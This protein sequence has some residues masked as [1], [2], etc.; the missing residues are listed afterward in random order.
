[1][2]EHLNIGQGEVDFKKINKILSKN[3]IKIKYTTIE[4]SK[5]NNNLL[6]FKEDVERLREAFDR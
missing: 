4:T 1:V 2:H 6:D 3:N 5:K